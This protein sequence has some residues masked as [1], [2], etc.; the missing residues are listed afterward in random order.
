MKVASDFEKE[1]KGK[2]TFPLLK[3]KLVATL[4]FEPSTRT[5]LSFEAAMQRL[6]GGVISMGAVE[7]SS[8]AK[9]ETLSDTV[10]T[11][12]QYA[13]VIVVRHPRIG[14]AKEAAD[15]V[16]IPV[17]NAGDGAGQHPTQ[18]LLDL[19]TIRKELGS[20]KNLKISLVGDLKNGRTVH[21]L[22]EVLSHFEA[23]LYFISP[24]LLRMPEE[25]T[26][27]MKQKGCEVTETEDLALGASRS[28]LIYMTRIQKERFAD[29]SEYEKVKG[30]YI[31][32]RE[33]IDRLK[34][35]ITILHPLPRVDEINPDVDSYP[36]AAYFRQMRNGVYV[37]MALL[38]MILGKR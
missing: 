18:A 23:S 13:D 22:V 10:R 32:N 2:S 4:F 7:S 14:S 11:V 16:D 8:V 28:D 36:G 33:F 15:A 31:I 12:A 3:G 21:A 37:R 24:N 35:K 9:G 27:R 5:R 25:I 6:G 1:L 20:L 34:K 29:L 38:A 26:I 30:S 17:V 19:Y